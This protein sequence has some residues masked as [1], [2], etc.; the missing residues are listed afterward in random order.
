MSK[1]SVAVFGLNGALGDSTIAAFLSATFAEKFSLPILAVTRDASQK[2]SNDV[3]KYVQGDLQ[4]APDAL[5][6]ALT[7]VDVVVSLVGAS[8]ANFAG[9]E[10]ILASIKPKLY[11]PSQF[12]IDIPAASSVFPG[13][14]GIKEKHLEKVRTLGIKV[15]DISTL[16]FAGGPWLRRVIGQVGGNVEEKS[17]RYLGSPESQFSYT[18]I[19]DIGKVVASVAFKVVDSPADFPNHLNV[20]SGFL[21][22]QEVIQTYEKENEV[23]FTV[24]EI[25]PKEL[26]LEEAKRVWAEGFNPS[27][28]LYYLNVLISQGQGSGITFFTN[29][30]DIV[31]P[32]ESLWKWSKF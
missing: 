24:K 11:I 28:F 27:K 13:L 7:G 30:N 9:L 17:V 5:A 23:S 32:G 4:N 22:P 21:T 29:D 19:T 12:G 18:T 3:V 8:P 26:V 10:Q 15:V 31:N 2:T 16:L 14:L 20:Q 6:A 25:V 1:P